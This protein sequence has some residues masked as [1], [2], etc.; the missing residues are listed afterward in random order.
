MCSYQQKEKDTI[1]FLINKRK[2][3][4]HFLLITEGKRSNMSSYQQKE[5]DKTCLLLTE[6]KR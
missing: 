2:E 5:R 4:K 6:G 3:I 1:C